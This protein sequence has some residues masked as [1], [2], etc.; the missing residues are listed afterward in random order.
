MF[1]D[2]LVEKQATLLLRCSCARTTN[3]WYIDSKYLK[4]FSATLPKRSNIW[5]MFEKKPL[6][7]VHSPCSCV[8]VRALCSGF[9]VCR[10]IY[11]QLHYC[12]WVVAAIILMNKHD[13]GCK[14][15][16]TSMV[17]VPNFCQPVIHSI[18]KI[19]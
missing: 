5:N 7:G 9:M 13:I 10:Y 1:P 15:S 2:R 11:V 3:A 16:E 4:T 17:F 12:K 18:Q 14:F 19:Q 8:C 6:P